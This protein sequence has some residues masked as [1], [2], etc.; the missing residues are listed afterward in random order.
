MPLSSLPSRR[1]L[2]IVVCLIMIFTSIWIT[3]YQVWMSS[4]GSAATTNA[5]SGTSALGTTMP[6]LETPK[7]TDV[8][9]TI[10]PTTI[11]VVSNAHAWNDTQPR[12]STLSTSP[13][14]PPAASWFN[15]SCE[16]T[17]AYPLHVTNYSRV[18][19]VT[20]FM[21]RGDGYDAAFNNNATRTA[22][23]R[24]Q[25]D[26]DFSNHFPHTMQQLYRCWAWWRRQQQQPST[27]TTRLVLEWQPEKITPN[28][29]VQGFIDLLKDTIGVEIRIPNAYEVETRDDAD[30]NKNST[31]VA[32][33]RLND[34]G[35][36]DYALSSP[37]DAVALRKAAASSTALH[38]AVPNMTCS[39]S[40]PRITI[41]NRRKKRRMLNVDVL[42]HSLK[43]ISSSVRVEYFERTS[44]EYQINVMSQTDILVSPHGAQ[45]TSIPFLSPC[46]AVLEIFPT[47][48]YIPTY[49]GSLAAVSGVQHAYLYLGMNRTEEVRRGSATPLA[50]TQTRAATI[51]LPVPRVQEAIR[52]LVAHWRHCCEQ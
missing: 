21:T 36:Y 52:T 3:L 13:P 33:A 29:F 22:I 49:F 51:C 25:H 39:S 34:G 45:L 28:P 14:P 1:H 23:C 20:K 15:T 2:R 6:R 40:F 4:S 26:L 48:Y 27:H 16:A 32:Q 12:S 41:L 18:R 38:L 24:F 10:T 5:A 37:E 46:A 50:R 47:G 42:R 31:V 44:F 17:A 11:A 7:K 30:N 9:T 35:L 8:S 43:N 19:E